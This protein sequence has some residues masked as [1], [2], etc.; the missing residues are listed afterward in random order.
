[1][2]RQLQ[3]GKIPRIER[4]MKCKWRDATNVQINKTNSPESVNTQNIQRYQQEAQKSDLDFS[5]LWKK[6]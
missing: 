3:P 2:G 6:K 1:M 5:D 4:S